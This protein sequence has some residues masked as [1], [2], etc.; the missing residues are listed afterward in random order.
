MGNPTNILK[1]ENAEQRRNRI[2]RRRL[3]SRYLGKKDSDQNSILNSTSTSASRSRFPAS[4]FSSLSPSYTSRSNS[5]YRA[6]RTSFT[7]TTKTKTK[8]NNSHRSQLRRTLHRTATKK[9]NNEHE[10]EEEH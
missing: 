2:L 10:L 3:Y 6:N 8:L 5:R 7:P 1:G 9:F 4:S